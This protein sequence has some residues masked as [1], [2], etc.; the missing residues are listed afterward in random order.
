LKRLKL[1]FFVKGTEQIPCPCCGG[2]LKVIGSRN[3]KYRRKAGELIE[4]IIRRLKCSNC[5]K[6]HHELPDNLVPYKRYD[7]E[8]IETVV[9]GNN[10]LDV[11]VDNSTI[12]RW[13]SW[14]KAISLHFIGCLIS[15][16]TRYQKEN[17]IDLTTFPKSVLGRI[18]FFV[19]DT[20]LW[21]ARV[22][23][24]VANSNNWLHTRSAWMT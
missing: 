3:R 6:I 7:C 10:Q 15:L 17:V 9:D 4:L 13:K 8:S 11:A 1:E 21:L 12:V 20:D 19:G 23:R 18:F 2:E 16:A 22:V 24:I 14:F 5:N